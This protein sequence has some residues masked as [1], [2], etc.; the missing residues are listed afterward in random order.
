MRPGSSSWARSVGDLGDGPVVVWAG[1]DRRLHRLDDRFVRRPLRQRGPEPLQAGVVVGEQQIVLGREVPI[2]RAKRH[3]GVGGDLLGRGVL[4]ALGE[5]PHHRR[6][7]QRLAR[8]LAARRLGRSDHVRKLPYD[9]YV[10]IDI[11]EISHETPPMVSLLVHA[12]LGIVV[13]A[14]V[15][16]SNPRVF[17]RVAR[18][19]Q[20]SKLEIS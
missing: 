13:I 20:L 17:T 3:P 5:E 4:D 19:P 2:E 12:I 8:A 6:L 9:G 1:Q 18:G 14:F 15:V 11:T 10:N 16:K 7:P